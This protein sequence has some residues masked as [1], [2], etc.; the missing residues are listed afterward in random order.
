MDNDK[1]QQIIDNQNEIKDSLKKITKS[2]AY[3]FQLLVVA[4]IIGILS[5]VS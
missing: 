1:L 4:F 2:S 5:L 3:T